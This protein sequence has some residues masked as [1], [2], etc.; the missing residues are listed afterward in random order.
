MWLIKKYY[1]KF[2]RFPSY[3]PA[4]II[5]TNNQKSVQKKDYPWKSR[6]SG[7]ECSIKLKY[8][9]NK[10]SITLQFSSLRFT[11]SLS[12]FWLVLKLDGIFGIGN[13]TLKSCACSAFNNMKIVQL[14]KY[15]NANRIWLFQAPNMLGCTIAT[16]E[17]VCVV[18]VVV[19]VVSCNLLAMENNKQKSLSIEIHAK[20]RK[21]AAKKQCFS[22]MMPILVGVF[23]SYT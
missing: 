4:K 9:T 15:Q 18:A 1:T 6:T 12:F 3:R 13:D 5:A 23:A 16:E 7:F 20:Y 19:V 21:K 8:I 10:I 11:I 22:M 14:Q 17:C 2:G